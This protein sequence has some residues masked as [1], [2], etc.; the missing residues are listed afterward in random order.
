MRAMKSSVS[1]IL[2]Y[3]GI[4]DVPPDATQDE[5]TLA[6]Y[7]LWKQYAPYL[8]AKDPEIRQEAALALAE[9]EE[10]Y[11]VLSDS[12]RRWLHDQQLPNAAG[13]ATVPHLQM[14][15]ATGRMPFGSSRSPQQIRPL[16]ISP[17]P[18]RGV[19][20]FI[21]RMFIPQATG[22]KKRAMGVVRKLLLVPIPFCASTFIAAIF[23]Q[24]GKATGY[25]F[26]FDLT[27]ILSYPLTLVW[28]F[29][30][31]VWFVRFTPI[32]SPL[33]KALWTPLILIVATLL[34]WAWLAFAD[35][36]GKTPSPLDIYFWLVLFMSVCLGL[37]YL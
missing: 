30:R 29:L 23:W 2:D 26:L 14:L 37:A 27:A 7:R 12:I 34:S 20:A 18:Q 10:A 15:Q 25:W 24:L 36:N 11:E 31:L 9:L 21:R 22:Q 33:Q 8:S 32:L 19:G 6:F 3:Y 28:L 17:P 4:L 13:S 1:D 16:P 35:H 5:I